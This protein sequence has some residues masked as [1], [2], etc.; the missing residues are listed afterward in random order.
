METDR[1][2]EAA[3]RCLYGWLD[4]DGFQEGADGAS[5]IIDIVWG[6]GTSGRWVQEWRDNPELRSPSPLEI[7][8]ARI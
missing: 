2:Q 3:K 6:V 8:R 7:W 1:E 4:S 5:D